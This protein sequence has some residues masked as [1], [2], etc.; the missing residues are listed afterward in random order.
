[1]K[2]FLATVLSAL[3]VSLHWA[4][5][6]YDG[7]CG[8][9]LFM[10]LREHSGQINPPADSDIWKRLYLV[11]GD[12]SGKLRNIF[13]KE[14]I[15][16]DP[17]G[18]SPDNAT[19]FYILEP[20]FWGA[21]TIPLDLNNIFPAPIDE[22]SRKSDYP[23]LCGA[24]GSSLFQTTY[25]NGVWG[26]GNYSIAQGYQI[27]AYYP[28]KGMEGDFARAILWMITRYPCDSWHGKANN[29]CLDNSFPVFQPYYIKDLLTS[30]LNDPVDSRECERDD[31]IAMAQGCG[32]PFVKYP[33]L[34][35]HIW[36]L[37]SDTPF[38]NDDPEPVVTPI[39]AIYTAA[40]KFFYCYSPHLP[41]KVDWFYFNNKKYHGDSPVALEQV[42][43]GNYTVYYGGPGFA[44]SVIIEIRK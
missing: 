1:M 41:A 18:Y 4:S 14:T 22:N 15:L 6:P 24:A 39:K 13:S 36:G 25:F 33:T 17:N 31:A 23:P 19:R 20:S 12:D 16:V 40:D 38:H 7:L 21:S 8:R 29:I 10:F 5:T 44:G 28:P 26:V 35:N 34:I 3:T 11:D 27:N 43:A 42:P 32:N 37:D 2:R 9:E 30:A